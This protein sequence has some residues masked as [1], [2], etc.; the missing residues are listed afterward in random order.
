MGASAAAA[1]ALSVPPP[2][3]SLDPHSRSH[4]HSQ[5]PPEQPRKFRSDWSPLPIAIRKQTSRSYP[6]EKEKM[7][8]DANAM[9]AEAPPLLHHDSS[10]S[11]AAA[12]DW[13]ASPRRIALFVEPSPFA[14]VLSLSPLPLPLPINRSQAATALSLLLS[15]F[16]I[17]QI[18]TSKQ[19]DPNQCF[20]FGHAYFSI[21]FLSPL[22]LNS[23]MHLCAV[24]WQIHIWIQESLSE[25]HQ[26][27]ARNGG[28]GMHNYLPCFFFP[29]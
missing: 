24:L 25:F 10:S 19:T 7:T 21:L 16:Q 29:F 17:S 27:F 18:K 9:D 14:S 12:A 28:R 4:S 20:R 23:C 22:I 2:S 6:K 1:A 26:A 13:P 15:R 3:R 8:L 11:S 5:D